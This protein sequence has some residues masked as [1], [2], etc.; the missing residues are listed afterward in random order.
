MCASA[1]KRQ[2]ARQ[3]PLGPPLRLLSSAQPP[4][5][6]P[7][8]RWLACTSWLACHKLP[9]YSVSYTGKAYGSEGSEPSVHTCRSVLLGGGGSVRSAAG[10][11]S[12]NSAR[13]HC[14]RLGGLALWMTASAWSASSIVEKGAAAVAAAGSD[15]GGRAPAAHALALGRAQ[16]SSLSSSACTRP[17]RRFRIWRPSGSKQQRPRQTPTRPRQAARSSPKSYIWGEFRR[18]LWG[19]REGPAPA[20]VV[21]QRSHSVLRPP[22]PSPPC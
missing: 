5:A 11:A 20:H 1:D 17:P 8:A 19:P 7:A 6:A 18:S 21:W 22:K 12:V 10:G 15:G 13:A 14:L 3:P 2:C 16:A 4:S 9:V